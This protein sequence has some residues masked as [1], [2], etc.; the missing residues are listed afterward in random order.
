MRSISLRV[1]G[2]GMVCAMSALLLLFFFPFTSDAVNVHSYSDT[3]SDSGPLELSNHTFR[4]KPM[5]NIH[6][7][8]YIEIAPPVGFE[9]LATSTFDV[10]NV[11]LLVNGIPRA[12]GDTLGAITDQVIIT[13]GSPGLIRYNLNTT[14]GISAGSNVE[15]RVGNHTTDSIQ[16]SESYSTT[17]GT[18][19]TYADI[20]PIRNA[21]EIGTYIF[22]MTIGGGDEPASADFNIALVQRVSTGLVDTT[23]FVPPVRYNGAP[24]GEVSG[25]TLVVEFSLR[26]NE[27]AV[28]KWSTASGTPYHAM[29]NTFQ[30][31]GQIAH[32]QVVGISTTTV[33]NYYVRCI[34]DEGNFNTDDYLISFFGQPPPTGQPNEEGDND[35]DGSGTGDTGHGQTDTGVGSGTGSGQQGGGGNSSGGGGSGGG[36][37]GRSGDRDDNETGGG[38][39]IGDNPYR[40]GDAE[41]VIRGFAFPG[42]TVNILVD[43]KPA[44]TTR[45]SN[46]GSY[47]I[48]LS[49]ISRGVYTFG[50]FAVGSDNVKS[51]TFST[52]FTV[53]GGRTSNLSNIN[54]MPSIKASPDPVDPGQTL[55][56]SGSAIPNSTV[57][58]ENQNERSTASRKQYTTTS[59]SNGAWSVQV[60]TNGF[61]AG[62]YKVR[63]RSSQAAGGIETNFSGYTFYG[64][65]EKADG[66]LNADLN[67]DGRVNLTDFSILLFWWGGD[68]DDSDPPA[69]INGDGT[70]SLTDF[71]ILLFNWTG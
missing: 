37:G 60:D 64:V 1:A 38:F 67:T 13:T 19:T 36:S 25:T 28:C 7:G 57:T 65:G 8:G 3:I 49:E 44:E 15:L 6:P 29:T 26:T 34:D 5:T 2:A 4:F 12:S 41:V 16:F 66:P 61:S 40:S 58:I 10:R 71:S 45:A 18:T 55:T 20:E 42:S 56:L 53:T 32:T 47:T 14:S 48:T 33:S 9:I 46:D 43:G 21:S 39:E 31:T 70:V 30:G 22:N 69:D 27:L 52:S 11:E 59:G 50:V 51:S 54:I 23:E 35:G 68:G 24:M 63:A 17:T 62:T